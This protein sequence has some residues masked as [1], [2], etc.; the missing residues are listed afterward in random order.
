LETQPEEEEQV[1]TA[2]V[3]DG[4]VEMGDQQAQ[5]AS[6]K[7]ILAGT[8]RPVDEEANQPTERDAMEQQPLQQETANEFDENRYVLMNDH[9]PTHG[10]SRQAESRPLLHP[11]FNSSVGGTIEEPRHMKK[12]YRFCS[13]IYYVSV[14]T[15]VALVGVTIVYYPKKPMYN[16]CNDAVAWKKIMTNI[17]A[18][19]LDASF[20]ILISLSN[21]NHL[22]AAL[23][24]GKGSFSFDGKQVGTFE[25]PPVTAD[26]MAINDLML[27]THVT[28]DRQQALELAEAYYMGKLILEA[29]FEGTIRLPDIFDF[30]FD[31][32]V[33]HIEVDV[34]AMSDRGLCHCPSW[35]DSKNHTGKLP[36]SF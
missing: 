25:I 8:C 4:V 15:V 3:E 28:P 11:S 5:R 16:V 23:D 30:T 27:I 24:R 6:G 19:K 1:E 2:N 13:V 33:K 36:T 21:P 31:V 34:N 10:S 35:D 26:A 32:S 12:L 7:S 20:E 17:A 29:E 18:L 14:L 9:P 22:V